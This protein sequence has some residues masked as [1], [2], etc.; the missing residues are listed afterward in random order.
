VRRDRQLDGHDGTRQE[1][2]RTR[3]SVDVDIPMLLGSGGATTISPKRRAAEEEVR[4]VSQSRHR[5]VPVGQAIDQATVNTADIK[6][7]T[8]N[9]WVM[10]TNRQLLAAA[11]TNETPF[12]KQT[13]R[14]NPSSVCG[15]VGTFDPCC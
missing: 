4:P 11:P 10:S 9:D 14:G 1:L 15:R 12:L 3:F 5:G 13:P 6:K 7:T 8:S 2:R